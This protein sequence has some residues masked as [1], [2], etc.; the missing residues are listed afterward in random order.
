ME[1]YSF[2]NSVG[3]D[4]KYKADDW[5]RYF[6]K[7]ITNGVFPNIASNLQVIA[8]GTNMT[9]KLKPGAAW[10]NG[11]MY[12]NTSDL[13]LPIDVADGLLNRI[14]RVVIQLSYS[15]RLIRAVVKKGA[16][17]SS[18][19]AP[20]LQRDAD[21]FELGIADIYVGKGITS[22]TQSIIT[23]LRLNTSLC[24]MVASLAQPD[25]TAIFNQYKDWFDRISKMHEDEAQLYFLAF[26]NKLDLDEQEFNS[27]FD[28]IKG[29]LDGDVAAKLAGDLASLENDVTAHKA[30]YV[31]HPG[32]GTTTNIKNVYYVTL[33]PA[34]PNGYEDKLGLVITINANSTGPATLNLNELGA[35][36][37]LKSNGNQVNNLKAN[38]VYT[39]RYNP[40]ADGG[41]GAFILQGEGASGNAVASDLL[42]GKTASTDAGDITGTMPNNGVFNLPMG[43]IVPAG[44]YSGGTVPSGKKW[45]SGTVTPATT[46]ITVTGLTFKPSII[47][48]AH[49]AN[50]PWS[51]L[52]ISANPTIFS[53]GNTT[54]NIDGTTF[55]IT[56][57][58]FKLRTYNNGIA[59]TWYAFE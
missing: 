13:V 11:Y 22:V 48:I 12:E 35:K 8:D 9:I 27:W 33:N 18:P 3:G 40:S 4:R 23:D 31:K 46:D 15:E 57:S 1:F 28:S 39:V 7:F 50:T 29:K 5:A 59:Y 37:I 17:L 54:Y 58:G 41:T 49:P 34:P 24:G 47:I 45:A 36:P 14:D 19:V 42:S 43:A 55:Y 26:K 2:F 25:T 16:F 52:Y 21:M 53:I 38:G 32:T 30:D 6:S 44:Y 10:I 51:T 20:T 56:N